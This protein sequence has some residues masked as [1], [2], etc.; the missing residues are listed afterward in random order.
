MFSLEHRPIVHVQL[1][2]ASRIECPELICQSGE[3]L[4][5]HIVVVTSEGVTCDDGVARGP[6]GIGGRGHRE[7]AGIASRFA[8]F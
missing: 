3:H 2:V 5:D 8:R 1:A 6:A 7:R 4:F